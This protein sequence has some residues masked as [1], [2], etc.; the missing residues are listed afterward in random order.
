VDQEQR[1]F[2]RITDRQVAKAGACPMNVNHLAR[3]VIVQP[4]NTFV[5]RDV[6]VKG[7]DSDHQ[8]DRQCQQDNGKSL[9]ELQ[10]KQAYLLHAERAK[11]YNGG[12][13]PD[14]NVEIRND[15]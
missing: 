7:L 2:T 9:Q 10:E 5:C 15:V 8:Q 4:A 6:P 3:D 11:S 1:F 14:F 13:V 12:N